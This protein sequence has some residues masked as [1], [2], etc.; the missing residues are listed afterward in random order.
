MTSKWRT[1]QLE[2]GMIIMALKIAFH[3]S[4]KSFSK[5]RW[6][7]FSHNGARRHSRAWGPF[8]KNAISIV[9]DK[10]F[11]FI[12]LSLDVEKCPI[13]HDSI[14]PS[15]INSLLIDVTPKV[16]EEKKLNRHSSIT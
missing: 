5:H 1:T 8:K 10:R 16:L 13:F 15:A 9:C 12:F 2:G 14:Y 7:L 3:V 11:P 6:L 4:L